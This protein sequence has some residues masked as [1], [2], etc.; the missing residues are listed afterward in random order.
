MGLK[1]GARLFPVRRVLFFGA[2]KNWSRRS[3]VLSQLIENGAWRGWERSPGLRPGLV[4]PRPSA[5]D[6]R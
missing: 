2:K 6:A 3:P 5:V 1:P 4:E